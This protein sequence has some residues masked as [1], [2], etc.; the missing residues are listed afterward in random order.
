MNNND[1]LTLIDDIYK[2]PIPGY[3]LSGYSILG[4]T[5]KNVEI[6]VSFKKIEI[7]HT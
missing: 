2:F 7:Y 5:P 1:L 4:E 6:A 3:K